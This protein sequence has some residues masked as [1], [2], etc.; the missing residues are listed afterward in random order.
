MKKIK[1]I[2]I[3]VVILATI[4]LIVFF[5]RENFLVS[6]KNNLISEVE[7]EQEVGLIINRGESDLLI[8]KSK[9]KE[10]MT[11]FS[12]L[13]EKSEELGLI[14]ETKTYDVGILIEAIGDKKNGQ[15]GKYW[16][17]YVNGEMPMVAS[18]KYKIKADDKVEFKFE[19]SIF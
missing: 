2:G 6:E 3:S 18:D 17:Y 10:G 13:E 7:T 4:A 5:G 14:L 11:A 8:L 15:D 1:I 19:K 12:L 16:M 9:F